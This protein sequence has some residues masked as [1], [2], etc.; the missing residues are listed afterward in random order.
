VRPIVIKLCFQIVL[1]PNT[2]ADI[3]NVLLVSVSIVIQSLKILHELDAPVFIDYIKEGAFKFCCRHLNNAKFQPF[4]Y[5]LFH[6]SSV[7]IRNLELFH[8]NRFFCLEGDLMVELVGLPQVKF[9]EAHIM[10]LQDDLK[11]PLSEYDGNI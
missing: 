5:M 3:L 1:Y 9:A 6:L 4:G 10:V 11:I 8:I 2:F 7:G